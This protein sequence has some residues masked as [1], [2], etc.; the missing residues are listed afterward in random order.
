MAAFSEIPVFQDVC[1]T[2]RMSGNEI[3]VYLKFTNF[4]PQ[5]RFVSYL[6]NTCTE[7]VEGWILKMNRIHI[8]RH[9]IREMTQKEVSLSSINPYILIR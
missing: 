2:V 6:N 7:P 3:C 5:V 9:R 4:I 8:K 1:V